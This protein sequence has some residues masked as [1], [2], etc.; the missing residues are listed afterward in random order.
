MP[1][2]LPIATDR[3]DSGAH[4]VV[5]EGDIDADTVRQFSD[6]LEAVYDEGGRQVVVDLAAVSFMDSSGLMALINA[7]N[8]FK[9]AYGELRVAR[10]S[11][12]VQ[13]LFGLTRMD[14]VFRIFPS[15]EGALD[16]EPPGGGADALRVS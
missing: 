3:H 13:R 7:S 15:R 8:H 16:A 5:P 12:A 14:A 6:A 4:L 9:R 10:P 11:D 1:R 2:T